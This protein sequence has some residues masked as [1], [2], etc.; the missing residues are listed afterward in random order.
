MSRSGQPLED[1]RIIV[2]GGGGLLGSSICQSIVESGALCV[3]A[4][5]SLDRAEAVAKH[6][7]SVTGLHPFCVEVSIADT[8]SVD[9][10]IVKSVGLMGSVTGLVNTAYPRNANYGRRFEEVTYADFCENTNVHL[11]GYFLV[12]QRILEH[13]RGNGGG[14]LLNMSSIYGVIAPRFEVYRETEMTMPVEYA[15]VKAGLVHLTKYLA[16][17][18]AG[19]NIRVNSLSLGGLLDRQPESFLAKYREYCLNKGMLD[20][21]DILGSVV[22]LLSD[23]SRYCNGQ[24]LVVDDGFTL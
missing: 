3:I 22:F 5:V 20:P 19:L 7:E 13:F 17:Y 1:Q 8:V 21:Q 10:M 6:I 14:S 11:G 15:A 4:D 18:Y 23:S 24:N 12:S 9:S 2:V 16:K